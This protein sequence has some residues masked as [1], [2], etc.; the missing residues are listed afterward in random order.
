MAKKRTVRHISSKKR[1]R[2]KVKF[3]FGMLIVIFILSF[4]LCFGLY[5]IAA[6][7]QDDFLK[8]EKTKKS[9]VQEQPDGNT[10]NNP[11][12]EIPEVATQSAPAAQVNPI[13]QSEAVDA[14][15]FDSCCLVTDSTLLAMGDYT[16][17]NDIIGSTE[18]NAAGCLNTQVVSDY[19]TIKVYE[20]IQFK[21]PHILYLMLGSDI[22][23]SS[24]DDMISSY[25]ALVDDLHDYLP[26]MRIYIMQL[27]PVIYDTET[28]TNDLINQ[29][30]SK[31]LDIAK[32]TGVYCIDTN[33]A[34]K[35]TA[36]GR[37]ADEYWNSETGTLS[38]AAYKKISDY[39]RT[40]TVP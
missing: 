1:S 16:S 22:G 8:D 25:S 34:L 33:T 10:E 11:E 2:P 26:D 40:H 27:P 14:T 5:M 18:L 4:A 20:I 28:V 23:T 31:L 7:T 35:A 37:L 15:Y 3:N 13:P 24:V 39:I 9:V 30:N 12:T 21:K 19:G 38:E 36:E 6:N 32:K 29:Y 17:L